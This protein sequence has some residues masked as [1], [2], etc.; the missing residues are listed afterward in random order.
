[1]K[2]LRPLLLFSLVCQC[3]AATACPGVGKLVFA[4]QADQAAVKVHRQPA[5]RAGQ[6]L[7]TDKLCADDLVYVPKG[8]RVKLRYLVGQAPGLPQEEI[9]AGEGYYPVPRREA[10]ASRWRGLLIAALDLHRWFQAPPAR[11]APAAM[12]A[13]GEITSPLGGT[14][15]VQTPFALSTATRQI[16]FI[17][18]GGRAPWQLSVSGP[19]GTPLR[20][21]NSETA[22]VRIGLPPLNSGGKYLLSVRDKDGSL[23]EKRLEVISDEQPPK[24]D[25]PAFWPW[26]VGRLEDPDRNWRLQ[27]WSLLSE[28]PDDP[29]K[30]IILEHLRRGDFF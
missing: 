7:H 28:A 25:S 13:R 11:P 9:V 23:F 6:W 17:W 26:A 10:S 14:G 3:A 4:S 27:V 5:L 19:D 22:Q 21:V 2:K 12:I 24:A 15:S 30:Q 8:I 16:D 18:H 1:M 20:Q 29:L